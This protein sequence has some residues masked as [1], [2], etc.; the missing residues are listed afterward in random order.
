MRIVILGAGAIGRLF[1]V[2]LGRA[3]HQVTLVDSNPTVVAAI[4]EYGLGFMEQGEA[5]PDAVSYLPV[6]IVEHAADITAC[7]LTLLT[8]KSHDTLTASQ[9]V[10]HLVDDTAP[11][12]TLQTGLGNVEL[13]EK[14]VGRNRILV[15]FTFMAAA[16]LG[17][18]IVRQGGTGKTYFGELDGTMSQ[19]VQDLAEMFAGAGFVCTPAHRILGRLWCKVIV[20]SA[21]NALSAVLQV[22]NGHLL[23]SMESITLMKRL[24]DEGEAVARAHSVDLVFHDLYA[25]LFASCQRTEQN[26]SSMLQDVLNGQRTE[27]EAQ[28]GAL[29]YYGRQKGVATPT[30]QTMVELVKLMEKKA[31]GLWLEGGAQ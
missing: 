10:A 23:E 20:F 30:H 25:V 17:P 6:Q 21:I 24:I 5:D 16:A 28:C 4:K 19:R 18:N 9:S 11:I 31:T 12:V 8:V 14:V 1:G 15:G 29:E 22:K 2:Y 7:E 13:L 3:G 27:I 26:I